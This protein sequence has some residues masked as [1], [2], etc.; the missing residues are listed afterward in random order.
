MPYILRLMQTVIETDSYLRAVKDAKMADGEK[1]A[2]VELV[3]TEPE[4]GDI[5]PGTGGV[6]KARLAGA[7]QGE[8]GRLSDHMV[9]WR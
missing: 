9:F 8:V 7:R 5:I 1:D 3:A 2:A 6:R 4:A